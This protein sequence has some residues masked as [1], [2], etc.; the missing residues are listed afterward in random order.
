MTDEEKIARALATN[1]GERWDANDFTETLNGE[2]PEE[3]RDHW[4]DVARVA[5]SALTQLGWVKIPEGW[6]CVPVEPT[7]AMVSA[8]AEATSMNYYAE[9]AEVYRAMLSAIPSSPTA[10]E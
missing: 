4:R 9:A 7:P 3:M 10:G 8:Y 5:L 1:A 2:T 6:K